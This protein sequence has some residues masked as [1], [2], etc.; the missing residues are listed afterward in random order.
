MKS[1]VLTL[2]LIALSYMPATGQTT[3][4]L[5][6]EIQ[7]T[8]P[9]GWMLGSDSIQY[10]FQIVYRNR[11]AEF[12]VFKSIL[13]ADQAITNEKDLQASVKKVIDNVILSLPQGK[14]LTNTGF[15]DVYRT[16]FV[17]EFVSADTAAQVVLRHRLEGLLYRQPDG[18]QLLFTLWGKA[19]LPRYP[20]LAEAMKSMQSGFQYTGAYEADVFAPPVR[21]Y[22]YL[23]VVLLLIIGLVFY[24]RSRR[25]KRQRDGSDN[26]TNSWTCQCGRLN[27]ASMHACLRCK[28]ER[29]R[30]PVA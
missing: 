2:L 18:H 11:D 25:V 14:L 22:W 6:G 23:Y 13:P 20:E 10:P 7:L 26:E 16:G 28:R 19:A 17:L 8:I 3:A 24:N 12:L 30:T 15:Y 21:S 29:V 1:I 4:R 27:P 9:Q 5:A